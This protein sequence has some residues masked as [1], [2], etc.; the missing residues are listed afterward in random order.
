MQTIVNGLLIMSN[1]EKEFRDIAITKRPIHETNNDADS[2]NSRDGGDD[3]NHSRG[4][5]DED[6][7]GNLHNMN[8]NDPTYTPKSTF[9]N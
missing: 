1:A 8:T 6:D 5:N 3:E 9:M 2:S 7:D 4:S